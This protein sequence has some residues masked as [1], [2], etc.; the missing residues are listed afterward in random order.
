[1]TRGRR[2]MAFYA[3]LIAIISSG[4]CMFDTVLFLTLGRFVLGFA[5]GLINLIYSKSITENFPE[6]LGSILAMMCNASIC[7]GIFLAF[8]MGGILPDPEDIEANKDD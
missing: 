2:K 6:K 4:I 3:H 5:A 7:I 8:V 1:M